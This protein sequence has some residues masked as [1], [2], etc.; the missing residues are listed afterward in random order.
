MA[1]EYFPFYHS[2][3]KKTE[4]LTDQ[5]LGR[6]VRALVKF[7][8]TGETQELAG[9]ESIAFDFI[10]VDIQN[11]R[12]AYEE[13]CS[14]N[15]ANGANATERPRTVANATERPLNKN[16]TKTKEETKTE[17][18]EETKT[19]KEVSS[20]PPT[21]SSPAPAPKPAA[22]GAMEMAKAEFSGDLLTAVLDWLSYKRER[23]E[24]YKEVGLRALFNQIR[25]AAETHGEAAVVEVIRNSMASGYMGITLDK[26]QNAKRSTVTTAANYVPPKSTKEQIDYLQK[27]LDEDRI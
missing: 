8:E 25:K 12:D 26:L 4:K 22:A 2:Y 18:E 10:S 14:K 15:R 9:R 27:M 19:E 20:S 13:K 23:R 3:G 6:L 21:P 11:A 7:S 24:P 16:K 1:L 5:E 17:A